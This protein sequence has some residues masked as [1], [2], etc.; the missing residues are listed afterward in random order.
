MEQSISDFKRTPALT[1]F[2]RFRND[3]P[4]KGHLLPT[5]FEHASPGNVKKSAREPWGWA[6]P[7]LSR[8]AE[9]DANLLGSGFLLFSVYQPS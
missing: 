5:S 6:E 1:E 7:K 9:E 8:V 2:V 3:H 4:P